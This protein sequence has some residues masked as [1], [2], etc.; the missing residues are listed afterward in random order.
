MR[1]I[2]TIACIFIIGKGNIFGQNQCTQALDH[3]RALFADGH[4]YE[5]PDILKECL[6]NGFT[7]EQ[8]I[9]AYHLLTMVNLYMDNHSKADENYMNLLRLDPEFD[10]EKDNDNIEIVYLNNKFKTTPIFILN[11][12]AGLTSTNP[13][14]IFDYNQDTNETYESRI[15][16]SF[17]PGIDLS[18]SENW[19]IGV[20]LIFRRNSFFY[21]NIRF[22]E[23][24]LEVTQ[25]QN[26]ISLPVS[27]KYV[28]QFGKFQ[29]YIHAGIAYD[30]LISSSGNFK[31]ENIDDGLPA[32][33][34]EDGRQN[35]TD[36][37][38]RPGLNLLGGV[39]LKKRINYHY[40]FI[41]F[42]Y[43]AGLKNIVRG[44]NRYLSSDGYFYELDK[45][46]YTDNDMRLNTYNISVGF[47]KPFYKPRYKSNQRGFFRKIFN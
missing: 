42:R 35:M 2:F 1:I 7:R 16:Y 6:E 27:V 21:K 36:R 44:E 41:E 4:L 32:E 37:R 29:P 45:F 38:R 46:T 47:E 14:I 10:V 24:N 40:V 23:D 25:H 43:L 15:G 33:I 28:R 17:G 39:G 22:G 30:Y 8:R 13:H 9:Q 5:V 11:A 26:N 19:K 34:G 18:I 31:Y 12:R 20:E 3:A